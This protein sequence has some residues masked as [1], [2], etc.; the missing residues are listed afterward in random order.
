MA[1]PPAST[2]PICTSTANATSTT[3]S[4]IASDTGRSC[5]L[6]LHYPMDDVQEL[7]HISLTIAAKANC[8]IRSLPHTPNKDPAKTK[9][10]EAW[11][12]AG[13]ATDE[14]NDL[15]DEK[16]PLDTHIVALNHTS[17]SRTSGMSAVVAQGPDG[18]TR[19]HWTGNINIISE[20]INH[21]IRH[22]PIYLSHA[23]RAWRRQHRRMN[24]TGWIG[25][26][27]GPDL[28]SVSEPWTAENL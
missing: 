15:L 16:T 17:M 6:I 2:P 14:I 5:S 18:R 20:F 3:S 8:R 10:C 24:Q 25:Q 1:C 26:K 12:A 27:R 23:V 9:R 19:Y 11:E 13:I 4:S 28:A 7:I 22:Y 21:F